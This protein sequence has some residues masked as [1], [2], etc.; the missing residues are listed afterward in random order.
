M[1]VAWNVADALYKVFYYFMDNHIVG[2]DKEND[3]VQGTKDYA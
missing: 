1:S 3:I 2:Y